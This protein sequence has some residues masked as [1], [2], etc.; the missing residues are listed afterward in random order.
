MAPFA[1]DLPLPVLLFRSSSKLGMGFGGV[2]GIV[3][4]NIDRGVNNEIYGTCQLCD[5]INAF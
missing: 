3:G 2:K 1:G 4:F 5:H